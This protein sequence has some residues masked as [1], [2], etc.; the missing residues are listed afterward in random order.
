MGAI[1]RTGHNNNE[2]LRREK[3]TKRIK[4]LTVINWNVKKEK[5]QG[6]H[7]PD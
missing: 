1:L 7:I 5:L 2:E 4:K 3:H 6:G